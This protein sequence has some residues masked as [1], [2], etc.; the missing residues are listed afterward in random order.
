[1]SMIDENVL[2]ILGQSLGMAIHNMHH[3]SIGAVAAGKQLQRW[4]TG[5]DGAPKSPRQNPTQ[6][7]QKALWRHIGDND[8][9]QQTQQPNISKIHEANANKSKSNINNNKH[10]KHIQKQQRL[11]PNNGKNR[12]NNIGS[13]S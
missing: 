5:K 3:G 7:R 12:N 10:D 6:A 8:K 1:M 9:A 13:N 4:E 2:G 11:K